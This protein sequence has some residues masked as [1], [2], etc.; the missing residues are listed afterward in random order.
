[1]KTKPMALLASAQLQQLTE[2]D[3]TAAADIMRQWRRLRTV[4]RSV[5]VGHR[6]YLTTTVD[7]GVLFVLGGIKT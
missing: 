5:R 6:I 1:M 3:R 7:R 4:R 2:I